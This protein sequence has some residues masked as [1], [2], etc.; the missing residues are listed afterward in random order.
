MCFALKSWKINFV[1]VRS[2]VYFQIRSADL[3]AEFFGVFNYA[4]TN[5]IIELVFGFEFD[6]IQN[7]RRFS[8]NIGKVEHRI[9]DRFSVVGYFYCAYTFIHNIV[10]SSPLI[11][12]RTECGTALSVITERES[13]FEVVHINFSDFYTGNGFSFQ[14]FGSFYVFI[15]QIYNMIVQKFPR[16]VNIL[17]LKWCWPKFVLIHFTG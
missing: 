5:I 8:V 17:V 11:W 7:E 16:V 3:G 14:R 4:V 12:N 1:P 6:I 10:W 13:F 9:S 15:S 2:C